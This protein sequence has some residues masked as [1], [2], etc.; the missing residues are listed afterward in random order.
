M[1]QIIERIVRSKYPPRDTRVL[2]LDTKKDLLK[3]FTSNGWTKVFANT[4][5]NTLRNAGYLFAGIATIDTNPETPD[6][7]VF[8]IANGKGTYTNF[9]NLEVTEDDVVFLYWDSS[10]HKVSTG[11]ASQEK[12][13]ELATKTDRINE[14]IGEIIK[15]S[16]TAVPGSTL[17]IKKIDLNTYPLKEGDKVYVRVDSSVIK[18]YYLQDSLG[19]I[20]SSDIHLLPNTDNLVTITNAPKSRYGITIS[21]GGILDTGEVTLTFLTNLENVIGE[22]M[23]Q[24]VEVEQQQSQIQKNSDSLNDIFFSR[25]NLF[26]VITPDADNS[27]SI[28]ALMKTGIIKYLRL[29]NINPEQKFSLMILGRLSNGNY[30]LRISE[31]GTNNYAINYMVSSDSTPRNHIIANNALGEGYFEIY[32]DWSRFASTNDF[33]IDG[34]VNSANKNRIFIGCYEPMIDYSLSIES[35]RN[36]LTAQQINPYK[37]MLSS[38]AKSLLKSTD[39]V[40]IAIIGDSIWAGVGPAEFSSD[41]AKRLPPCMSNPCPPYWMYTY[42]VKN[43]PIWYRYDCEEISEVGTWTTELK[44]FNTTSGVHASDGKAFGRSRQSNNESASISFIWDLSAY[45]K[46]A[47]VHRLRYDGVSKVIISVSGGN[48]KVLVQHNQLAN[49]IDGYTDGEWIEANGY[50]F[51]QRVPS[52]VGLHNGTDS[53]ANFMT[54]FKIA[55]GATGSV[56]ITFTRDDSDTSHFMYYWGFSMWNGRTI[57]IDNCARGGI[58]ITGIIGHTADDIAWRHPDLIMLEVP[59]ANSTNGGISYNDIREYL[60]GWLYQEGAKASGTSSGASIAANALL[61]WV[62]SGKVIYFIA[63][64]FAKYVKDNENAFITLQPTE[65]ESPQDRNGEMMYDSAR[66]IFAEKDQEYIDYATMVLNIAEERGMLWHDIMSASI[67]GGVPTLCSD[68]IH[69]S[70]LGAFI[71]GYLV[72]NILLNP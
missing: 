62:N 6:A 19:N 50:K 12:L 23:I 53:F 66:L 51:T 22:S 42:G 68:G 55:D 1:A 45:G 57:M 67:K 54:Y 61:P 40:H 26:E 33:Y 24:K 4:A 34:T 59:L 41:I 30:I 8:Y 10:W 2:W 39:D 58:S 70:K 14:T 21:K 71:Q 56:T 17:Q 49:P 60:L 38:S 7:K 20:L 65:K 5:I 32:V 35:F 63:N 15:E 29:V 46:M 13:T 11:I 43:K 37:R 52:A 47:F 36:R 69:P 18:D 3:A 44:K 72:A 16:A 27:R 64:Y 9:G 48:G 25:I 28:E 31:Y